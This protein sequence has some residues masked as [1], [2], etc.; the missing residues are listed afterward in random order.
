VSND[1]NV[2]WHDRNH[3]KPVAWFSVARCQ[4]GRG[5]CQEAASF[6]LIPRRVLP[7]LLAAIADRL[8]G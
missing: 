4:H 2:T 1:V 6:G 5:G 7:Q 3:D 8:R